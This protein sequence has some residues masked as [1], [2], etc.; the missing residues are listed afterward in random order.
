[1]SA[2]ANSSRRG[3]RRNTASAPSQ[4][5]GQTSPRSTSPAGVQQISG[6]MERL[7]LTGK[8]RHLHP[9][10]PPGTA[11]RALTVT[12]NHFKIN[13][14]DA[15]EKIYKW[16]LDIKKVNI[17]NARVEPVG[18]VNR[19]VLELLL[20]HQTFQSPVYTDYE[21]TL[22][23]F[24][25]LTAGPTSPVSY[26]VDYYE[27]EEHGPRAAPN[28]LIY[29]VTVT[30]AIAPLLTQPL[31]ELMNNPGPAL[32]RADEYEEALNIMLLR[33]AG[34]NRDLTTRLRGTKVFSLLN[35]NTRQELG[36]GLFTYRGYLR[37]IRV[38]QGGLFLCLNTTAG[39]M[40]EEDWADLV[41][42]KWS[43][44]RPPRNDQDFMAQLDQSF[45]RVK[46]KGIF[47]DPHRVKSIAGI[48]HDQG[49]YKSASAATF[50]C[51]RHPIINAPL[52]QRVSVKDYFKMA[53]PTFNIR[54]PK[55]VLKV[56]SS[57]RWILWP[58][59]ACKILPGQPYKRPMP[60]PEQSQQ[61][62]RFACRDP[63]GN[64]NFIQD[65]GL[66]MLG[67]RRIE[68]G[69]NVGRVTASPLRVRMEMETAPAR[70][71][72]P[73]TI[74]FLKNSMNAVDA[75][76]GQWNLRDRQFS[77]AGKM[78]PYTVLV[79]REQHDRPISNLA[80]FTSMLGSESAKY[81]NLPSSQTRPVQLTPQDYVYP[82]INQASW[83]EQ[84][85]RQCLERGIKYC[86]VVCSS[87]KWY[88]DI[89]SVADKIG[90]QTTITLRKRDGTVK[91]SMGEIANLMLK[92]NWKLGGVNWSLNMSE[93]RILGGKTTM[94]VGID[95]VHAPPGAMKGAPSV[96]AVVASTGP[97]PGQFPGVI[98]LQHHDDA[99]KKSIEMVPTLNMMFATRLELWAKLNHGNLPQLL[100]I[101]RDGVSDSQL[102]HVLN[103]EVPLIE[104]ACKAV[105][106]KFN[107]QL[108]QMYVQST[109]K[110]HMVRFYAPQN[111][112]KNPAFDQ[113][114]NPLPGL[115]VDKKIVSPKFDDWYSVSHKCL[116]GTSRPA[117]NF[118]ILDQVGGTLDD[119]QAL[120]NAL[121]YVFGRSV[122]SISIPTP[123]RLA[124]RLCERAKYRLQPVYFP[125]EP[126]QTY[127]QD[128]A[129]YFQ[130]QSDVHSD[131]ID[132][133]YYI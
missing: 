75:A 32:P 31:K 57:D 9:R 24:Y 48:F 117:H 67:V 98:R 125:T 92:F 65:E 47:R 107:K 79:F 131:L 25:P 118:R 80:Q 15:P 123:A 71:L 45:Q 30:A 106:G 114:G 104:E 66:R 17:Q 16:N 101:Y 81:L 126:G 116:Q 44:S 100:F 112:Q 28:Q 37:S 72:Q 110:R 59:A 52:N 96:A 50:K 18:R 21:K 87:S 19:R 7:N 38:L 4:Q 91:A 89:K 27:P 122:T 64:M 99:T 61:M 93:F 35:D 95:V 85:F 74:N 73:P 54:D 20:Q 119:L 63:K 26:S 53:Y 130:G 127:Q 46:V 22:I 111:D 14:T 132:T 6:V 129:S 36:R 43:P 103:I 77:K 55:I 3:S 88:G 5:E 86:F 23:S 78:K 33:F 108:P 69:A 10:S 76:K 82:L 113:R 109:Q 84:R 124:D 68:P 12:T 83:L 115:V 121:A 62:I 94:F 42:A 128:N 60:F 105:Y 41:I 70:R 40:W 2:S 102:E 39:V 97:N 120:T 51:D 34:Q 56:G 58:A 29:T 13:S 133:M 11:G 1:M 8:S 49:K 90:M